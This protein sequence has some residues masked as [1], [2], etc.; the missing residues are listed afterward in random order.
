MNESARWS[1]FWLWLAVGVVCPWGLCDAAAS[2]IYTYT[3]DQ[4]NFVASDSLENVPERY[5]SRAKAR[6][7]QDSGAAVRPASP[8]SGFEAFLLGLADRLPKALTIPG[9]NAFQT[10]VLVAGGL[11]AV[12]ML[13]GMHLSANPAVRLLMKCLL[14]FL[15]VGATYL[16]YFSDLGERAA[17]ASGQPASSG[18]FMQ[19]ARDSAK[20]QEAVHQQ[21]AKEI[22]ALEQPG[23]APR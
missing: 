1:L 23:Q 10:I 7:V 21:R 3:D 19:K 15:V 13:A 12:L 2:E 6:E 8:P 4:G 5:R 11:A 9:T 14:G 18:T 20:M 17:T 16:M 22:E